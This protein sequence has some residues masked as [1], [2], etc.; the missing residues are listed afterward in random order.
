MWNYP[1]FTRNETETPVCQNNLT[2]SVPK[3]VFEPKF[4]WTPVYFLLITPGDAQETPAPELGGAF[5]NKYIQ[6][7]SALSLIQKQNNC[8]GPQTTPMFTQQFFIGNGVPVSLPARYGED[9]RLIVISQGGSR[10]KGNREE[11]GQL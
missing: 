1:H 7:C 5:L 2:Y 11:C 4:S 9:V 3:Q 6:S 8:R 10:Q